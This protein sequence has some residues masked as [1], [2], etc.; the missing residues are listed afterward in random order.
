MT[1]IAKSRQGDGPV[2][3]TFKV[4]QDLHKRLKRIAIRRETS[5]QELLME[6]ID[7]SHPGILED[8]ESKTDGEE[9]GSVVSDRAPEDVTTRTAKALKALELRRPVAKKLKVKRFTHSFYLHPGVHEAL[10]VMAH[11]MRVSQQEILRESFNLWLTSKD[12]PSWA[13]IVEAWE[14]E[15]EDKQ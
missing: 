1:Y 6:V 3:I 15:H 2:G 14:K 8:D 7:H 9:K 13:E 11:N 12:L 5:L 4:P 10:K